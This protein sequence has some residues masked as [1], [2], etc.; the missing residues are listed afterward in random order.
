MKK[1]LLIALLIVGCDNS[2][3]AEA[4]CEVCN[5]G[6]LIA[7]DSYKPCNHDFGKGYYILNMKPNASYS[8]YYCLQCDLTDV[9][10]NTYPC[11]AYTQLPVYIFGEEKMDMADN[12]WT[13]VDK[14]KHFPN[15][16]YFEIIDDGIVTILHQDSV[17]FYSEYY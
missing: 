11:P 17:R 12:W 10:G 6:W 15:L 2:T 7:K 5:V 1:L 4:S 8:Q 14:I 9:D 13:E 3:E 16:N